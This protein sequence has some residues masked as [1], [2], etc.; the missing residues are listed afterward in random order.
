MTLAYSERQRSKSAVLKR[1]LVLKRLRRAEKDRLLAKRRQRGDI[2]FC[3]P[4]SPPLPMPTPISL[5][6]AY[7]KEVIRAGLRAML[8]KTGIKIVAEADDATGT[9]TL[10]KKH[11]PAVV[12]LD[13]AIPGGDAF[14]LVGKIQKSISAT[15][16]IIFSA[17]DNPTYMAR[18]C[19]AG[20]SNFLLKSVSQKELV[21]AIEQAAAG[22]SPSGAGPFTKVAAAMFS[23]TWLSA[24]P[25]MR[26]PSRS[27]SVSRPSKS[28][29]RTC[30]ANWPWLTGRKPPCGPC[31]RGWCRPAY[32]RP[33]TA[34]KSAS[35]GSGSASL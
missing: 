4:T 1:E 23:P 27:K 8:E 18:A 26:L 33:S 29:S 14:D 3:I 20:A 2:S 9:L 35:S 10:A 19:A 21:A 31:G 5:L 17:V 12:L 32:S 24:C 28:T 6:V 15:K 7:P 22:K 11:K 13:A 25:T 16:V 34:R 30:C